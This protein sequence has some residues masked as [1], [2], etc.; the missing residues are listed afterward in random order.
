VKLFFGTGFLTIPA[1]FVQTG[2]IGGI[3]LYLGIALLNS[4]TMVNMMH[5]ADTLAA[6]GKKV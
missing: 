6:R 3:V 5:V 1:V 4:Y 2:I